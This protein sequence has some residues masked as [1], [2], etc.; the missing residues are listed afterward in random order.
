MKYFSHFCNFAVENKRYTQ[1]NSNIKAL[2]FDIDGTLVSFKT[3]RIPQSTVDALQQAKRNGVK[4]Y[5]STGR[6]IMI[7]NNL[8]QI[9]HL[10]DGY[11][12]TNGAR[13][14]VG[15]TTVCLHPI[16]RSD[17]MEVVADAD[18]ND[19]S[20]I[21]VGERHLVVYHPTDVVRKVFVEGLGVTN[22]DFS[23]HLDDLAHE[24]V[25]QLTPFCSAQQEAQLMPRLHHCNS[26]RW[27][28]AFTDITSGDADKGK[29]L[30][31]MAD[32]LGLDISQTMAF[33]DGGNDISIISEAGIG[34][35]MGNAGD[36]VKAIADFVTSSVDEDGVRNALLHF[37]VI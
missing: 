37:G 17:V 1:M 2:F 22:L 19:Y 12:T 16:S 27:H 31:A 28:P 7:I 36:N 26:G 11:I 6:P 10:I 32:Y 30:H 18:R 3:H 35:A 13:C 23:T 4:V 5:I 14:F 9:D 33:G 34:V 8:G 20:V 29:G 25:L 21:V 15:D 24:E